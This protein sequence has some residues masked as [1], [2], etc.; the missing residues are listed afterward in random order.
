MGHMTPE[1]LK[2]AGLHEFAMLTDEGAANVL[3]TI[4]RILKDIPEDPHD[5]K[6]LL[7]RARL[8]GFIYG[9]RLGVRPE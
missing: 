4:E 2:S 5:I 8:E 9:Y 3:D 1:D 6:D 7:V